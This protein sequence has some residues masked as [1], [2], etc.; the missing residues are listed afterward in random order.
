MKSRSVPL[1][2]HGVWHSSALR[3][4]LT[5]TA[6]LNSASMHD[7]GPQVVMRFKRRAVMHC[8]KHGLAHKAMPQTGIQLDSDRTP[9]LKSTSTCNSDK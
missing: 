3:K 6:L 2:R 9:C 5:I 1:T 4:R 8:S 7:M